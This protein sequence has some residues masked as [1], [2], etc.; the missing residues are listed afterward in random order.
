VSRSPNNVLIFAYGS[1]MDLQQIKERCPNSDLAS[2][3][4]EARGWKL[5]FPRESNKRK[6]G[7]GS[8]EREEGSSVWGVVF[9]VNERD[10]A[11]LDSHEGVP[12]GR[13]ARGPVEVYTEQP[14]RAQTYFAVRQREQDFAPP[15]GLHRPVYPRRKAFWPAG[16]VY[17]VLGAHPRAS[18]IRLIGQM[19][20][21]E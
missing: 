4:A 2:F 16:S 11:S 3:L 15:S 6:G 13:Y 8:I 19:N 17:R 20:R 9:S 10:L 12:R 21:P 5:C 7:V 18:Q 14:A 1:N